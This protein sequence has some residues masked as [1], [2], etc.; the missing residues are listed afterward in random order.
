MKV[1][2]ERVAELLRALAPDDAADVEVPEDVLRAFHQHAPADGG[3][4]AGVRVRRSGRVAVLRIAA[5][6]LVLSSGTV[7]A[8][9]TDVLPG[10]AQRVA[11][12]LLG[13]WGVPAP[14]RGHATPSSTISSTPP[15]RAASPAVSPAASPS[16]RA[17]AAVGKT[18]SGAE[19]AE[20]KS[21]SATASCSGSNTH[22]ENGHCAGRPT[23]DVRD[24]HARTRTAHD[25]AAH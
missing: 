12:S 25:S 10:P 6:V 20:D 21:P 8:A 7:A 2:G 1:Y 22:A 19:H 3:R 14:H 16:A 9:A 11:H 17:T 24:G 18:R 15:S 4:R 13:G 5:V 23:P